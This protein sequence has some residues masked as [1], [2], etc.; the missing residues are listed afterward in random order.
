MK[1]IVKNEL[2]GGLAKF[3]IKQKEVMEN[4]LIKSGVQL[5]NWISNG[6][7]SNS[8][9]PPIKTGRLR[10]SGSVFFGN[11]LIDST[12][13]YAN[14]EFSGKENIITI[15]YN[16]SYAAKLHE[17]RWKPGPVSMQSGDVGNKWI[18]SHLKSDGKAWVKYIAKLM[19][20]SL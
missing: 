3:D 2:S 4:A 20:K 13:S 9:V 15:G 10:G 16:T 1:L 17:K 12:G 7:P 14:K 5:L 18:E 6:S 8:R 11:R 19:E